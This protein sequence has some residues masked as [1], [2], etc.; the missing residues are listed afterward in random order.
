MLSKLQLEY[1]QKETTPKLEI[2]K[3]DI[4]ES[5]DIV[6]TEKGVPSNQVYSETLF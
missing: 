1:M 6:E 4:A 3:R 2:E 5:H